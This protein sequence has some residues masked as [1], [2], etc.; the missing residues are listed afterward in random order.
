MMG[1][2]N[3]CPA[4]AAKP[5]AAAIREAVMSMR[6]SGRRDRDQRLQAGAR[7]AEG[8]RVRR[9]DATALLEAVIRPGDRVCLEGDNQ[10][11]ADLLAV[12]LAAADSRQAPRSA[13]GAIRRG[14]AGTSR[15]VRERHRQASGLR[16]FRSPIGAHRALALRRQDRTGRG[17]HVSGAIRTL[18]HRPDAAGGVDRRGQRR[19]PRQSVHRSEYRGHADD[20]R[21]HG[22]QGRRGDR[23][24]ERDRRHAAARRHSRR[25]G[26]LRG[27]QRQTVLC[28][29]AVHAR[30]GGHHRDARSSPPC[31][32]SRASTHPTACSG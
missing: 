15:C 25:L 18:L 26:A 13:P 2:L 28:G 17:A 31:W 29:A 1:V 20:R 21:S 11:Q 8:K 30:S 32:R 16:L 3:H 24:G 4:D 22:L 5:V 6:D 9:Q 12:A 14:A 10:K 19:P 23:P 27:R 7:H